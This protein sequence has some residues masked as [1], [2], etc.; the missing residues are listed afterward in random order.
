M[1]ECFPRFGMAL[2]CRDPRLGPWSRFGQVRIFSL[3]STTPKLAPL[4]ETAWYPLYCDPTKREIVFSGRHGGIHA[5]VVDDHVEA[6][7]RP[8][9]V[10]P[11][12]GANVTDVRVIPQARIEIGRD[13]KTVVVP[14]I[15]V[16]MPP[17]R[18]TTTAR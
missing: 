2:R 10:G 12:R 15:D 8:I 14:D 18:D 17:K 1:P 6:I 3:N 7:L 16:K 13:T 4:H 5:H 9:E 11:R